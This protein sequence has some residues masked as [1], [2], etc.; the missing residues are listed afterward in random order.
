MHKGLGMSKFQSKGKVPTT[1]Y[2]YYMAGQD[3]VQMLPSS[4]LCCVGRLNDLGSAEE[5]SLSHS[6]G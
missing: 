2:H 4:T 5:P 3:T 1:G 6:G